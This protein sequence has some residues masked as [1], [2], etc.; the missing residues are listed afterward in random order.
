MGT[1]GTDAPPASPPLTQ[2]E[3]PPHADGL[4]VSATEEVA[5]SETPVEGE[6]GEDTEEQPVELPEGW[7]EHPD[8]KQ[9]LAEHYQKAQSEFDRKGLERDAQHAEDVDKARNEGIASETVRK[10]AEMSADVASLV[11]DG[12]DEAVEK[13]QEAMKE[14]APWGRFFNDQTERNIRENERKAARPHIL[15]EASSLFLDQLD[16]PI[17]EALASIKD[18]LNLKIRARKLSTE[19][20]YVALMGK[21]V[22]ALIAHAE[23][24]VSGMAAE[25][26][27]EEERAKTRPKAPVNPNGRG[28]GG[29]KRYKD[30][31]LDEQSKLSP[32]QIDAMVAQEFVGQV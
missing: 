24:T 16:K 31:T 1:A 3:Q 15:A 25:R 27:A 4:A 29:T 2:D 7:L 26:G 23:K 18:E 30:M 8:A 17:Q 10:L 22:D 5:G 28:G 32:G 12:S 20:A 14:Y 21:A 19:E 6:G 9:A 11:K 13:F